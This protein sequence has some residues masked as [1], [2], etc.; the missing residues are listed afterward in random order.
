MP[1][2]GS[3]TST[4]SWARRDSSRSMVASRLAPSITTCSR[5]DQFWAAT[6]SRQSPTVAAQ[7]QVA[8]MIEIFTL[9]PLAVPL[10][11][12]SA[13]A[14]S[15]ACS[16]VNPQHAA[17]CR[18]RSLPCRRHVPLYLRDFCIDQVPIPESL[19]EVERGARLAVEKT[20]SKDVAVEE[21]GECA[22]T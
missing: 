14:S 9:A 10:A 15:V 21:V 16:N 7:F 22:K 11:A 3:L 13:A 19:Q 5:F 1:R 4:E 6:E 20:Y 18:D 2:S 8:V 17:N 12:A